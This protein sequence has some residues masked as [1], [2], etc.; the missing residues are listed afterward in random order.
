MIFL[1]L[2][3]YEYQNTKILQN[4]INIYW[5]IYSP[6]TCPRR[7]WSFLSWATHFFI[8]ISTC[9]ILS[10]PSVHPQQHIFVT[11]SN[12]SFLSLATQFFLSLATHFA[13]KKREYT[14]LALFLA[15]YANDFKKTFTKWLWEWNSGRNKKYDILNLLAL[16]Q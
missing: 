11:P 2:W 7:S 6:Y 12:T 5:Y 3:L 15:L 4:K 10:N 1:R 8:P 13:H 9:F 16:L 14:V